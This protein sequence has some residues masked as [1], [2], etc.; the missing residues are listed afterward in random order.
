MGLLYTAG[1]L[2]SMIG[3]LFIPYL[4]RRYGVKPILL[5]LLLL[6]IT[7]CGINAFS[8]NT[9][10]IFIAF[11]LLVSTGSMIFLIN[12]IALD[13]VGTPARMGSIRGS[14]LT[15]INIAYVIAPTITGFVLARMGFSA[16]YSIAGIILVP[17]FF[18]VTKIH[19]NTSIHQAKANI[20]KSLLDVWKNKDIKTIVLVNFLLQFFYAWMV[21]YTPIY[22][23][24]TLGIPWDSLGTIFSIMLLAFVLT[25]I[26]LGKLADRYLGEKELL[27]IGSLVMGGS[28]M[29]LF[30]LPHFTLPVLVLIL[31]LTRIGA[32]CIEVMS[33]TYFFKKVSSSDTGTISIFRNTYPM[34]YIIAPI[35]GGGVITLFSQKHLFLFLGIICLLIIPATIPLR[36]TR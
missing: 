5:S 36:D 14:Y 28:T 16:L 21:L 23:H 15:A 20:W 34:A 12:D 19:N 4:I 1:S 35:I 9:L 17:L 27:I 8:H 7:I 3:L 29:A 26:P 33:E 30:F 10:L 31:F 32:S 25:E 6:T 11:C 24:Q 2:V 13:Q 22:L 18:V